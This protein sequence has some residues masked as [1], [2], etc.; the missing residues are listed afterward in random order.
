MARILTAKK[1][2]ALQP[3]TRIVAEGGKNFIYIGR[4]GPDNAYHMIDEIGWNGMS[5]IPD[6]NLSFHLKRRKFKIVPETVRRVSNDYSHWNE[7]ATIIRRLENP[8]IGGR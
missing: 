8:E 1:F 2:R 3:G 7:E 6:I 4:G 5:Y